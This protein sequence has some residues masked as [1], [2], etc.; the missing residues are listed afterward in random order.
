MHVGNA[1]GAFLGG[2]LGA[3]MQ[4]GRVVDAMQRVGTD[5]R[6]WIAR[7]LRTSGQQP[8]QPQPISTAVMLQNVLVGAVFAAVAYMIWSFVCM[9]QP[10]ATRTVE[11]TE[12]VGGFRPV[13][14]CACL[15]FR[16]TNVMETL[17]CAPCMW[18]ETAGKLKVCGMG[19]GPLVAV[20]CIC[21]VVS[22]VTGGLSMIL[23]LFFRCYTRDFMRH[24]MKQGSESVASDFCIDCLSHTC[25]A[26]CAIAQEAEFVEHYEQHNL[27][28]SV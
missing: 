7:Q 9:G 1:Y 28:E 27:L 20:V 14:L 2:S 10:R 12:L 17:C 16:I 4:G 6:A 22:P 26:C 18:A 21:W 15:S 19:F 3:F 23:W 5:A 24:K 25:C 8:L 11:A 13:G